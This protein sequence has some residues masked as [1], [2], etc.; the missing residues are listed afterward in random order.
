MRRALAVLALGTIPASACGDGGFGAPMDIGPTLV[1]ELKDADKVAGAKF[2]PL[3]LTVDTP[4]TF[5]V[6]VKAI[7]QDGS[8]DAGFNGY[9]RLSSKP[10]SIQRIT[11]PGGDGRNVLLKNGVSEDTAVD[12]VNGYGTTFILADDLGYQPVDPTRNPP[13]ACAN[14]VDD[15][16]DNKTDFPADEG[17]AF[18]NDDTETGGTY[19]QGSTPPIF[20]ALPRIADARGLTCQGGVCAG[21]GVTPYPKEPV[22]LDTGYHEQQKGA[23]RFDFDTV[24]IRISASGFFITDTKDTRGG[25][26]SLFVFNF[27]APPQMR[28]CDRIKTFAGTAAEFFGFTQASYPTWTLEEWDPEQR[29]CLVPEPRVL[30]LADIPS[31]TNTNANLLPMTA[32]LVRVQSATGTTDVKVSAKLGQDNVPLVNKVY[33][34]GPNATNCDFNGDG[35]IDFTNNEGACSTVCTADP[36]CT[37]YS[38]YLTRS[39]FRLKVTDLQSNTAAAIQADASADPE[40]KPLD[41]KGKS[42]RAFSGVLTYF[43]GGQQF[44]IEARC[45]DDIVIDASQQPLPSDHACVFPRTELDTNPD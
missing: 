45:H 17:C 7:A 28:V 35:K 9:V 25:F 6:V 14:G 41:M 34:P 2:Q 27:S 8:V 29:P 1:V 11:S 21:G 40:F 4:M 32:G 31:T 33:V 18:P 20:F 5:H 15:D 22:D 36:D 39:V 3:P 30:G 38:N 16:G 43:S 12:L 23:P 26:N 44:T 42:L 37:E 19:S 13:P 10:G 24:V